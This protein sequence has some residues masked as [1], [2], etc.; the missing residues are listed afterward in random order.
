MST[1]S[2]FTEIPLETTS[3]A[4]RLRRIAAAV[5]VA[6]TWWGT[7]RALTG[8]QKD[9]VC[10]A[11]GADTR[12]LSAG[13]RIVDVAHPAFR[14]LTSVR[15]QV[16]K[17]W[18]S[19]TLPYVDSGVRLIRQSDVAAFNLTM[20]GF[21]NDLA[22]AE[23]G[24]SAAFE[25]IKTDARKRLGSLYDATDYPAEIRR[26]FALDWDYP[27]V[28]PPAYLMR[29]APDVYEQQ[30]ERVGQR[31]EEAVQLAE[32]AFMTEFTRLLSH[33]T[34]RL[35]D[36]DDGERRV[37]RDSAVTNLSEFFNRFRALNIRSNADLDHLVDQARQL[38][39]GVTPHELRSNDDL[40]SRIASE[41][42]VV[43]SQV[44]AM[45]IER[46]RRSI[47]RPSARSGGA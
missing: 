16:V 14:R 3:A 7:H 19:V 25:Q 18:R 17:H 4:D 29:L 32:Q 21:R 43:Q 28:E 11:T 15:T 33:L 8:D 30:K 31:F 34:E 5:R 2:S 38:V 36:G 9:A 42:S 45:I 41:M 20:E 1:V 24:L 44:D 39:T 22:H 10:E 26:L 6:F 27:A 12:L 23:R 35:R 37:F 46:P 47:I 13:K 40:R